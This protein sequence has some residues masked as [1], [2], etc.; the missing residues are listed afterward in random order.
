[1][2]ASVLLRLSA[3]SP[4]LAAHPKLNAYL[5]R[6]EARPAFRRAFA[7]QLEV[8]RRNEAGQGG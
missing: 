3:G 6:A 8:F 7:A 5:E 1:M 2:M 4:L